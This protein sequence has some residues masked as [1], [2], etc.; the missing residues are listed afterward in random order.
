MSYPTRITWL[1]N[2]MGYNNKLLYWEPLLKE[3]ISNFPMTT[4]LTCETEA[5]IFGT[6]YTVKKA[7]SRF[8]LKLGQ[9][10]LSVP[11]PTVIN[12]LART[13]P[14]VIVISEFGL[15]SLYATLYRLLNKKTRVLLLVENDPIYLKYYGVHRDGVLYDFVRRFIGRSADKVL[16]NNNKAANYLVNRLS[17]PSQKIIC[18]CYLTSAIDVNAVIRSN[19]KKIALLFVG[20]LIPRK[21]L[22]HLLGA[23]TRLSLTL[24]ANLRL[25]IVGDG[26]ERRTLEEL[27]QKYGLGDVVTLH[28]LQPYDKLGD[29]FSQ[30][31]I[32][33]LPTLGDYRALVGFE[34]LSAGLPIIGSTFDG[35]ATEIIE[36]A[37]NGFIVD[38]KNE[39]ALSKK[40]QLFLSTPQLAVQFGKESKRKAAMFTTNIA[41]TNLINACK[42]C[43]SEFNP[44]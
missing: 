28:G 43:I 41:A 12:K 9:R 8:I 32:F 19:N 13:K 20:Q 11:A 10:T 40:I 27:I 31:D 36:E 39:D 3:L 2:S 7:L 16:C 21:G 23:I 18:G 37:V 24:R 4:I 22:A 44:Y 25:D 33:V 14:D 38:P 42:D 34:A 29:F 35:A 30:A 6:N 5:Q 15:L 1:I 26:P 17:I